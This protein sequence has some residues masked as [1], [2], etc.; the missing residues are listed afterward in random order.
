MWR[1]NLICDLAAVGQ[2]IHFQYFVAA[3]QIDHD[4]YRSHKLSA[5]LNHCPVRES[6]EGQRF[7]QVHRNALA[8]K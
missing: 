4:L 8:R 1:T 5:Y 6:G 3:R 7:R 2:T